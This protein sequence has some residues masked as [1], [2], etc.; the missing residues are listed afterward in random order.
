[1]KSITYTYT[2]FCKYLRDF[3]NMYLMQQMLIENETLKRHD[4]ILILN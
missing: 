1:M 2:N 3:E 4:L